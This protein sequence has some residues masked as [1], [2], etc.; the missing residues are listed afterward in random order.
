MANR[1]SLALSRNCD[2][3]MATRWK[4]IETVFEQALDLG[5]EER[6]AFLE[7][8]CNGDEEL[9][10]EVE[11]LLSAHAQAG[12]FI[13]DRNHFYHEFD[14]SEP[15]GSQ[16]IGHYRIVGE[17]GRGGMGAVYLAERADDEY[18]KQVAIKLI[19][20]GTDTDSVLRHFRNERQI[21]AGFDHPNIA[22]LLDGGTT[23][24]GVPY[25]VMEYVDGL[26]IDKYCNT[27]A[28]PLLERLRL[29]RDVCAAVSYAHRHLVVHRDLKRSNILVTNDGVPKLLDFGIA[30]I[31]QQGET[32]EPLATM[33]SARRMTPEY[34][35]PEQVRGEPM[36]TA[37]D[38]YSLGVVLYEL[39]TGQ[40]P[41]RFASPSPND[42]ACAITDT[43]PTRPSTA[44]KD[45]N[46]ADPRFTIHDSRALRGDLDNIL[47]MALRKEPERRYSSVD[48]FSEDIRRHLESLPVVARRDTLSYRTGKFLRRHRTGSIAAG[49][50][51]LTLI[52]GII[53]TAS[54]LRRATT[55]KARAERRF[56]D[57][58][59][60]AHSVLFDYHDAIKDLPGATKVRERLV[61]DALTYLD[62]LAAETHGD[63][64][65]Q[66]EL[67]EAYQRVGDVRGGNV[68]G[69]LG[70]I[71]GA[72]ES[73]TKSLRIFETIA[74]ANPTDIETRREV[75]VTHQLVGFALLKMDE[76][77]NGL[78]HF[79]KSR[80]LYYD[81][82]REQHEREDIQLAFANSCN[83][84]G[85]ALEQHG[86]VASALEQYRAAMAICEKM[87]SNHPER[88]LYRRVL[89]VCYDGVGSTL[90]SQDD[91]PGAIAAND[92]ALALAEALVKEDPVNT[93]YRRALFVDYFNGGKYRD[94]SDKRALEYFDRA[95]K[96]AEQAIAA[97]PANAL[98]RDDL[99]ITQRRMADRYANLDDNAQALQHFRNAAE[100]YEKLP[101]DPKARTNI[102][103]CR[104]GVAGMQ[105]RLGQLA[106]ALDECRKVL[107]L[108]KEIPTPSRDLAEAYEHLGSA[109]KALAASSKTSAN[110]QR[111]QMST[112]RDMFRQALKVLNDWRNQ[113]TFS[114]DDERYV[115]SLTDEMSKSETAL[116]KA[117]VT[118]PGK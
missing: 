28:L 13:D 64:A 81:M 83:N 90:F 5:T 94:S 48:Q 35:S 37:S 11:S 59:Q 63:P 78:E 9:R 22:R 109:H 25:F 95:L 16:S 75:A 56:N 67:A 111:E 54:A 27:H 74:V 47:L 19:K 113:H 108:L 30:K 60:L 31:L 106:P 116:D 104:A 57:V 98:I 2:G 65:L 76:V 18:R 89:C 87:V 44:V 66:H 79:Q 114:P 82:A 36:T 26:P 49:L 23:E 91:V 14:P 96:L 34:A 100:N 84:L 72:L 58:R 99:A 39:L 15:A 6:I 46:S 20:R 70:D 40:F 24:D 101:Q 105:A 93:D 45:R 86:D 69:N 41:Y 92:K 117:K 102:A 55:E 1:E 68:T 3:M 73:Y 110:E 12:S 17:L 10:G 29:F 115:K 107:A 38:V 8:A 62:S 97:D 103:I 77:R 21:L 4:Q 33:T 61:R 80:E 53:A 88:P 118:P 42:I 52:G 32:G 50:I 112:V 85:F 7:Q 51:L 43:P 71:A